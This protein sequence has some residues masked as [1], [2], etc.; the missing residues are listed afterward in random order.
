MSIPKGVAAADLPLTTKLAQLAKRDFLQALLLFALF[1]FICFGLGYPTLNRYDPTRTD[2]TS[3]SARYYQMIVNGPQDFGLAEHVRGRLLVPYLAKPFYHLALN[4]IKTWNPVFFA[5]LVVNSFF[6]AMTAV[7]LVC[8][9]C[10]L[11]KD[12]AVALLGACLYLLNFVVSNMQ[13]SGLVDS[14]EACFMIAITWALLNDRWVLLLSLAAFG[15]AAKETFVPLASTFVLVWWFATRSKGSRLV[16]GFW[17]VAMITTGLAVV[18][19][20]QSTAAG[21]LIWPWTLASSI[22]AGGNY[23]QSLWRCIA[24]HEIEYTLI[25][26]LPLGVWRLRKLP[27]PWVRASFITLMVAFALGAYRDTLG[28]VAR[29]MFN[30]VGAILSLSVAML[31]S[32]SSL[33][34]T[35]P[36]KSIARHLGAS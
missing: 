6:T 29:P 4:R 24:G 36:D 8:I 34:I 35:E 12:R 25:W 19:I 9:G 3:D 33:P 30:A 32:R 5:L 14:A 26:L 23:L 17:V 1:F 28:S 27:K 11:T 21:R 20:L 13:L 31:L 7:I 18:M 15:A 16:K 22:G 2:G 10:Q